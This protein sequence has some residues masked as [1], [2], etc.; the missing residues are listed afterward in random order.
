MRDVMT[1]TPNI[2][3]EAG[4]HVFLQDPHAV[5]SF[6]DRHFAHP[7]VVANVHQI[8]HFY[9]FCRASS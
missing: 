1:L 5:T 3:K 9:D 8:K 4:E 6:F 2:M 7:L